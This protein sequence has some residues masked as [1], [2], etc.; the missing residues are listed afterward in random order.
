MI[1]NH[2]KF[3]VLGLGKSGY[4]TAL[5]LSKHGAQVFVSEKGTGVQAVEYADSLR[6]QGIAVELG[7]HSSAKIA[8]TDI[9]VVSPGI[10]PFSDIIVYLKKRHV[11]LM[12]E[13]ELAASVCKGRIIAITGTNG[14]TTVTTRIA[15]V[16]RAGGYNALTCGNI[17]TPF[18]S[19]AEDIDAAGFAVLEVSSFQL[20]Y[21]RHI[22][23]WIAIF[24]NLAPDHL[25]WHED[26]NDYGRSKARLFRAQKASDFAIIGDTC[27]E[28]EISGGASR[29]YFKSTKTAT[30]NP[31]EK[32][33][34]MVARIVGVSKRVID[35]SRN[36]FQG[37][38]H[39]MEFVMKKKDVVYVN[40]SKSTSPHSLEWA[41]RSVSGRVVLICGGQNKGVSFEPLRAIVAKKVAHVIVIGEATDEIVAA[42]EGYVSLEKQKTLKGAV[43][44]ATRNAQSGDMVLFSPA[45]ASFDMFKNYKHRGK[46]FKACVKHV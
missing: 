28:L 13:I 9:V 36:A 8:K 7:K 42:F 10:A 32:C 38:E 39:R 17:G 20:Y 45:C 29:R 14:K 41:L 33:V 30:Y 46:R 22:R 5:F 1:I 43:A 23:P 19:V 18:I 11:R 40:D 21:S 6:Q 16:L 3:A 24:L 2:K 15:E 31:N 4:E 27:K 37:I 26:M 35:Q 44:A 25:N 12:S 34:G